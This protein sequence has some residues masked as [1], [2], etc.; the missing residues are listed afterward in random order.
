M[1]RRADPESVEQDEKIAAK[2]DLNITDNQRASLTYIRN[3]GTQQFQQNAFLNARSH[4]ACSPTAMSWR[5]K[6]IPAC[7]S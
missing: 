5:K 1:T 3:T 2:L 4:S 6:S 7:S